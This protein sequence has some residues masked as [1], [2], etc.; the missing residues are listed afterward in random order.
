MIGEAG[1]FLRY[2]LEELHGFD[3]Q[4][5]TGCGGSPKKHGQ[6]SESKSEH[7]IAV[8]ACTKISQTYNMEC[9]LALP[10]G[11]SGRDAVRSGTDY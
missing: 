5:E 7:P 6:M 11:G 2:A 10:K 4:G 1:R 8:V 9:W 3:S